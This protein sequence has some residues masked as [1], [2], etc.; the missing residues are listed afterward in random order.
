MTKKYIQLTIASIDLLQQRYTTDD[1]K[2]DINTLT[3]SLSHPAEEVP[4]VETV[5]TIQATEAFPTWQDFDDKMVFKSA[6]RG[7][8]KLKVEIAFINKDSRFEK[9]LKSILSEATKSALGTFTKGLSNAYLGSIT[10]T[11]GN[12]LLDLAEEGD[13]NEVDIIA[14]GE[15]LLHSDDLPSTITLP[16]TVPKTLY[17]TV[18]QRDGSNG[19][20]PSFRNED[21]PVLTQGENGSITLTVTLLD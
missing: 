5:K 7:E 11:L 2:E 1:G 10:K 18:R 8:S 13:E 12:S 15:M 16:L 4:K 14:Q 20:R 19:K 3:F 17:K 9:A 21:I 6:I